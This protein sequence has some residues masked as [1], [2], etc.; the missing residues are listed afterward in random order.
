MHH[1]ID[2][3]P[4]EGKWQDTIDLYNKHLYPKMGKQHKALYVPPG[5]S[6]DKDPQT[7]CG[8]PNCTAVML[9][10]ADACYK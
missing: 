2:F 9:Q 3:Y 5:Y 10:W 8:G 7:Y 4:D 1:Q 6:T